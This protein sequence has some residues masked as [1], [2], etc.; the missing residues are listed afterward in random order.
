MCIELN[1]E[2]CFTSCTIKIIYF[3]CF[4]FKGRKKDFEKVLGGFL[5]II[6]PLAEAI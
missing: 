1:V 4:F 5:R 6:G 2:L 3:I